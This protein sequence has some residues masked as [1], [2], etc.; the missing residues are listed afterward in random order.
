MVTDNINQRIDDCVFTGVDLKINTRSDLVVFR[1]I[2]MI[3][4]IEVGKIAL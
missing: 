3:R 1:C 2:K 4:G